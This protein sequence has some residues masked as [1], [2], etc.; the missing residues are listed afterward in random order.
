MKSEVNMS[1]VKRL[2]LAGLVLTAFSVPSLQAQGD[3]DINL[4][5]LSGQE[6]QSIS[7]AKDPE[8]LLKV[9][10]NIASERLKVL[11]NAAD[12]RDR[13]AASQAVPPFRVA[14]NGAD[15]AMNHILSSEK[16][17]KKDLTLLFKATRD[18]ASLLVRKI[19]KGTG[20]AEPSLQSALEV[21]QRVQGG[22]MIQM[23]KHGVNP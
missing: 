11:L 18:Q 22:L 14:I 10:I 7:Q 15:E 16:S 20:D 6:Q 23:E 1:L 9:Y 12:K 13:D 2:A 21:V 8:T 19:Q 3:A 17:P 5:I 4:K